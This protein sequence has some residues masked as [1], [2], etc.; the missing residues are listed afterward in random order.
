[1]DLKTRLISV[2][3]R[4]LSGPT[5]SDRFAYQRTWA[6][7]R[8]ME[9]HA[10][11]EDYVVI[12]DHHE[13]VSI[14]DSEDAPTA[15]KGYQIKTKASGNFTLQAM[16]KREE[17]K[18]QPPA[19]LPSILGKLYDLKVRFPE[20]TILLTVVSNASFSL[21]LKC[22]GK[23]STVLE[24]AHVGDLLDEDRT[25]ICE[26]LKEEHNIKDTISLDGLLEFVKSDIPLCG[27]ETHAKGKL[28]EFLQALYPDR[29]FS[30]VPLYRALDS[31]VKVRNNNHEQNQSFDDLV[32]RKALSRRLFTE[33]LQQVGVSPI[34]VELQEVVQRLNSE[35]CPFNIVAELRREWDGARLDRM[36]KRDI[37]H[38]RLREAVSKAVKAHA[39]QARLTD[40]MSECYEE[41]APQLRGE[42]AF[43]PTYVKVFIVLEAYER[44]ESVAT[45][46]P[47][48]AE[49]EE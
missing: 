6:L 31:E 4:D 32:R 23:K 3:P 47:T 44:Y 9:L 10:S 33:V 29:Q 35:A 2:P 48:Q 45:S 12:F 38:L 14:L 5:A 34:Q 17:G 36:E 24:L 15:L 40:L 42:W 49:G 27:H 41:V 20:H 43:A 16:L 22:D 11:G 39:S 25:K 13:D 28:A 30:I 26:A 18:S 21:R 37:P 46:S 8:V 1:M 19:P 7:C